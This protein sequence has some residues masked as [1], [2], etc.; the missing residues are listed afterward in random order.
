M[1][2]EVKVR[3]ESLWVVCN[4]IS[5]SSKDDLVSVI[6]MYEKTIGKMDIITPLCYNLINLDKGELS[7]LLQMIKSIERLL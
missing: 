1:S 4:L 2:S 3:N 7:L 6:K 5:S